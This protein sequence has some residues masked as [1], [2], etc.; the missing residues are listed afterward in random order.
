MRCSNCA[1]SNRNAARHQ[2]GI[3]ARD[4]R[5]PQAQTISV[6]KEAQTGATTADSAR[7]NGVSNATIHNWKPKIGR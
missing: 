2:I 5:N 3:H 4:R 7:P 6:L 1:R